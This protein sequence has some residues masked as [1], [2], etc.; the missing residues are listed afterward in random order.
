MK[1]INV[2][3]ADELLSAIKSDTT[4]NILTKHIDLESII[5]E[6][7]DNVKIEIQND[8]KVLII[9]NIK[10]LTIQAENAVRI[11]QEGFIIL[12][13]KCKNVK[14]SNL[15]IYELSDYPEFKVNINECLDFRLDIMIYTQYN[16]KKILS[17]SN[18]RD[19]ILDND[20]LEGIIEIEKSNSIYHDIS[21]FR[22]ISVIN[23]GENIIQKSMGKEPDILERINVSDYINIQYREQADLIIYNESEIYS[24]NRLPSKPV[25]SP[26]HKKCAFIAPNEWESIGDLYVYNFKDNTSSILIKGEDYSKRHKIKKVLWKSEDRLILII[27]NAYGTISLGGNIFEYDLIDSKIEL[28]YECKEYEEIKDLFINDGNLIC[29]RIKFDNEYNKFETNQIKLDID[30]YKEIK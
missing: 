17:I 29:T 3:N 25:I 21:S 16:N 22:T 26:K 18:S 6:D 30:S 2:S 10:N 12:F 15:E 23:K 19:I 28:K 27:G 1:N 9:E 14:L 11:S 20:Q 5:I 8:R 4:I 24:N 7:T 13:R